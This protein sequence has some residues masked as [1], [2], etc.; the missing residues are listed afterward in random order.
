VKGATRR[1]ARPPLDQ[2]DGFANKLFK[3]N[4]GLDTIF[5]VV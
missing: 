3:W 2:R 4:P 1:D 5:Y